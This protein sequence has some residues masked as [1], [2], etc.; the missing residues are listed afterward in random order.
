[1]N[2]SIDPN[3]VRPSGPVHLPLNSRHENPLLASDHEEKGPPPKTGRGL[4]TEDKKDKG[5][6]KKDSGGSYH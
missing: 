5:G 4:L 3:P 2:N 6:G 1:M